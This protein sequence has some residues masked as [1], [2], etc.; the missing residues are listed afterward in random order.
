MWDTVQTLTPS[1]TLY[2]TEAY[3]SNICEAELQKIFC[4]KRK[5]E[6]MFVSI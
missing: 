1:T 2:E 4:G 6:F 5:K 3:I